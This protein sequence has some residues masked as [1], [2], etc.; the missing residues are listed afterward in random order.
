MEEKLNW[1]MEGKGKEDIEQN[2]QTIELSKS[3][4]LLDFSNS[5]SFN[6]KSKGFTSI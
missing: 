2:L 1:S 6:E 3:S 5:S 4:S